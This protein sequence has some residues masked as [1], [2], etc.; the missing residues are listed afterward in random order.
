MFEVA[1]VAPDLAKEALK[2]A[3]HKLP[4]DTRLVEREE[5]GATV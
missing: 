3:G 4:I 5:A 2:L 1:G